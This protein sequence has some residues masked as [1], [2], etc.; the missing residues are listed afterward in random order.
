MTYFTYSSVYMLIPEGPISSGSPFSCQWS[1]AH[2]R[3]QGKGQTATPEGD[4]SVSQVVA[5]Q[6]WVD[7]PQFRSSEWR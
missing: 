2:C 7:R 5:V 3:G 1:A 6:G 4:K